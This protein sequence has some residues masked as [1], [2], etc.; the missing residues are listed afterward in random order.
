MSAVRSSNSVGSPWRRA[1]R[2]AAG[3]TSATRRAK[4]RRVDRLP[5][6]DDPLPVADEMRLGRLAGPEPGRAKARCRPGRGRCPSRSCRRRAPRGTSSCGSPS[7]RSSARVRPRPRRIPNL[8]RASSASD[9]RRSVPP[10]ARAGGAHRG[11]V[12]LVE[13]ALVEA[14]REAHVVDVAL[15]EM[16]AAA[17]LAAR[18]RG[19]LAH[20]GLQEVRRMDRDRAARA[21]Q[22][23]VRADVAPQVRQA[24]G[25][26]R[27]HARPRAARP[28]PDGTR[29]PGRTR[30]RGAGSGARGAW[31]PYAPAARPWR[32]AAERRPRRRRDGPPGSRSRAGAGSPPGRS[33]RAG[34]PAWDGGPRARGR[35]Q[36][37]RPASAPSPGGGTGRAV[38]RGIGPWL[39]EPRSPGVGRTGLRSR[40]ST[41]PSTP[42]NPLGVRGASQ[43]A[44]YHRAPARTPVPSRPCRRP[45]GPP[46]LR[47]TI[48][49]DG[50]PPR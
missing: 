40:G 27:A 1:T 20:Q 12:F 9:G 8:P 11:Q 25:P 4:S 42:A 26:G 34:S 49:P 17:Q 18:R 35:P 37:G 28:C 22:E 13:D 39:H 19:V 31:R 6:D 5:V 21:G 48:A 10:A 14:R 2:S 32:A 41:A 44:A 50:L 15:L 46:A 43:A 47:A 36:A 24:E 33:G 29:T 38:T 23:E 7:S 45:A 3:R 30:S 16:D